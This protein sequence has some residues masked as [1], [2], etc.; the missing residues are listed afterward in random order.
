MRKEL[1]VQRASVERE[2]SEWQQERRQLE[3]SELQKSTT[4][5]DKTEMVKRLWDDIEVLSK[6]NRKLV[7]EQESLRAEMRLAVEEVLSQKQEDSEAEGNLAR[8]MVVEGYQGE[9]CMQKEGSMGDNPQEGTDPQTENNP[10]TEVCRQTGE[11]PQNGIV[12]TNKTTPKRKT[13]YK[14]ETTHKNRRLAHKLTTT[15]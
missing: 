4:L 8:N 3:D 7:G 14:E 10:R 12:P 6:A 15:H 5:S 1:D 11:N 13:T 9:G 2:R